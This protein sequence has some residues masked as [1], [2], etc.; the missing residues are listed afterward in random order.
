MPHPAA[1]KPKSNTVLIVCLILG[2]LALLILPLIM[3]AV[4]QI[5]KALTRAQMAE[6]LSN[7]RQIKLALDSFAMDN[8]G[9]YPNAETRK[10]Y[11]LPEPSSSTSNDYFRQLFA[12]GNTNSE[13]VFWAKGASVCSDNPPDDM[14]TSSGRFD[15]EQTLKTGDCGVAYIL[16]QQNTSNPSRPL[17]LSAFAAGTGN[18]DLDQYDSKVLIVQIDGSAKPTRLPIDGTLMDG[19]GNDLLDDAKCWEGT[20]PVIVQPGQ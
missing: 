4:P 5:Y 19:D 13:R 10:F 2:G 1:R 17:L 6:D 14:T 9:V 16:N 18:F 11:E 12:S 15:P 8:D 20:P 7:M 3:M